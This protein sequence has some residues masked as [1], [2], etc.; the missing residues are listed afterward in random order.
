MS[1][2][3]FLNQGI[4]VLA[5]AA[6]CA[7]FVDA[8]VGGGGLIQIP[9]LFSGFPTEAPATLFGTNKLS[10]LGGTLVSAG[11]YL[12]QIRLPLKLMLF[13]SIVA[14]L[15]SIF[16]AWALTFISPVFIR[17]SLP[18]ILL[19]LLI[20]T[21][22]KK[23]SA[24][25][26]D[27]MQDSFHTRL[28]LFLGVAIIGFYDGFLG[29][30]TGSFLM[31]FFVSFLRYDFLH[32]AAATKVINCVT[33]IAALCLFIPAGHIQWGLAVVMV[34]FN[35]LGGLLGSSMAMRLG[36]DFVK[37]FFIGVVLLLIIKTAID[38]Y[39]LIGF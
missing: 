5:L 10:A 25:A 17:V 3:D 11:R 34:V 1:S 29:P 31:F 16:G 37:K 24:F 28:I 14:F 9:A 36:S 33:N 6:L 26:H 23:N 20:F 15:T 39:R 27:P 30:G 21:L 8:I 7:G 18:A 19:G 2:V 38:S 13:A 22:V 32:A 4:Y 12:K 35:I